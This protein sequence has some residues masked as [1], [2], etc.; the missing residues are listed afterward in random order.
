MTRDDFIKADRKYRA[1]C[2]ERDLFEKIV[3]SYAAGLGDNALSSDMPPFQLEVWR[4]FDFVCKR[5]YHL[6]READTAGFR[7]AEV[8]LD[9]L[10]GM[11]CEP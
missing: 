4:R 5:F 6:R 1:I 3:A 8:A 7:L 11:W 2:A 10:R 9:V